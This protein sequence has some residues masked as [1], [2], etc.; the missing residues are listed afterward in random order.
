MKVAAR[1]W[2]AAAGTVMYQTTP[3]KN[4][5]T[6]AETEAAESLKKL[7]KSSAADKTVQSVSQAEDKEGRDSKDAK[8][9]DE[10]N[11]LAMLN[12]L[13]ESIA[14]QKS[15]KN[16][17]NGFNTSA[18]TPEDTVGGLAALLAR[19]ETRFDV[20]QVSGKAMRALANLRMAAM[21]SDGDEA[22]KIAR[23][24][25]RMEKLI[26]RIQKKLQHLSKEEQLQRQRQRAEKK[27]EQEKAQEIEKEIQARRKKRRRDERNYANKQLA[28]DGK[29]DQN[30]ML[31]S[32]TDIGTGAPVPE[33]SDVIGSGGADTGGMD[34][35][36]PSF[37]SG[38]ID[39]LV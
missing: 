34:L 21:A 17:K 27:Q 30:D 38:S 11:E 15:K 23:N 28:E 39:M 6:E 5:Q 26:K 19:S 32:M 12:R 16:D 14:S 31:S 9:S 25:K 1:N 2:Q 24:I 36:V 37:E 22:K 8:A 33:L 10:E 7:Q 18:S 3:Q 35:S 13:A 29:N 4:S 20:L